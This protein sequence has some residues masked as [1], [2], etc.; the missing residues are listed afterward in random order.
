MHGHDWL[1]ILEITY[2]EVDENGWGP[3]FGLIKS[4]IKPLDHQDL[5]DYFSGNYDHKS[6]KPSAENIAQWLFHEV[7]ALTSYKPDFVTVNEGG[8]NRV[9]YRG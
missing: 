4:L 2:D 1:A 8:A 6:M 3:D 5:N 9:T 7:W